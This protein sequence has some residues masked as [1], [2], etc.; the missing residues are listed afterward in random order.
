MKPRVDLTFD[1]E[2]SEPVACYDERQGQMR[3]HARVTMDYLALIYLHL[4][5]I[6]T[7]LEG[8]RARQKTRLAVCYHLSLGFASGQNQWWVRGR[9]HQARHSASRR[10]RYYWAR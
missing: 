1:L 9:W 6:F 5:L 8:S 7:F 4:A 2:N 3:G 10:N